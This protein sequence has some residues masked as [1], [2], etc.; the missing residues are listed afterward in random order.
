LAD[1]NDYPEVIVWGAG[2]QAKLLLE[3]SNFFK[4]AK[5]A[6]FVDDTPEKIGGTYLGYPI[7]S[8]DVLLR[9]DQPVLI[10]AVQG[11][12]A[13]LDRFLSLGIP[14]RRLISQLVL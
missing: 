1:G 5:V 8:S 2:W 6:F 9:T 14:K 11:Y 3:Q 12:P 13:I 4:K 7:C 10:A